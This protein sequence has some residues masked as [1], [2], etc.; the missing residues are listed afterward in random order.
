MTVV[1][2]QGS[3]EP[4]WRQLRILMADGDLRFQSWSQQVLLHKGVNNFYTAAT[5]DDALAILRR[6]GMDL[7]LIDVF[8]DGAAAGR[9]LRLLRDPTKSPN[10]TLPI[11]LMSK[12]GDPKLLRDACEAGVENVLR[13]P[14]SQSEF[15]KRLISTLKQPRRI[16]W[17]DTYIGPE[18]RRAAD[19]NYS[20]PERRGVAKKIEIAPTKAPARPAAGAAIPPP[21]IARPTKTATPADG[22]FGL[23]PVGAG[24]T[25]LPPVGG[26][27]APKPAIGVPPVGTRGGDAGS[28]ADILAERKRETNLPAMRV[29]P[30]GSRGADAPQIGDAV[31]LKRETQ[32]PTMRV[33]PVGSRGADT[34]QI[35]DAVALKRETQLP[36]MRVPPVGSRGA[37]IDMS[38]IMADLRRETQAPAKPRPAAPAAAPPPAEEEIAVTDILAR[39][40]SEQETLTH[41]IEAAREAERRAALEAAQ[42]GAYDDVPAE[43]D[44]ADAWDAVIEDLQE[45]AEVEAEEEQAFEAPEAAEESEPEGEEQEIDLDAGEVEDDEE[46]PER[47]GD[48]AVDVARVLDQHQAWLAS[49]GAEGERAFLA[50]EDLTGRDFTGVD[51]SS[52]DLRDCNLTDAILNET[53]LEA[54]DL[55]G[56]TLTGAKCK[57]TNFNVAKLR[58]VDFYKSNLRGAALRGADLAGAVLTA[59]IVDDADMAGA[60]LFQSVLAGADLTRAQGLV[61]RQLL[62]VKGDRHTRLPAGLRIAKTGT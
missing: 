19:P 53:N 10:A 59:A 61:Q 52:A 42:S 34:P 57:G 23:S 38:D 11:V 49:K 41:D 28:M 47:A 16:V 15:L 8:L 17:V 30:V 12:S 14:T 44:D 45:G 1:F 18:R 27:L 2:L 46:V 48:V 36:T 32:L 54:A 22:G 21:G 58:R 25:I 35:G 50:G 39:L 40:R 56:A 60:N 51:L 37:D 6:V 9:F 3:P 20:G 31:A 29:P 62:S 33:P 5:S 13:K 26:G 24:A 4:D 43:R 55:R 7:L